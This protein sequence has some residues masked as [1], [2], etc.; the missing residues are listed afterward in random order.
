[1]END[2]VIFTDGSS[3]P[4]PR[5]GGLGFSFLFPDGLIKNFSPFGYIGATNNQME[6]QACIDAL[7]EILRLKKIDINSIIIRTD[8]KYVVDYHNLAK[9]VWSKNGWKKSNG[10]FVL[11]I[12]QW[13]DLLS[14]ENRIFSKFHI[15]VNYEKIKGHKGIEGN[16]RAHKSAKRSRLGP[17]C[18]K[19]ISITRVRRS[20]TK[21][22]TERGSICGL[23]QRISLRVV[24]GGWEKKLFRFRCEVMSKKSRFLGNMDFVWSEFPLSVGHTYFVVLMENSNFCQI[25]R[26]IRENKKN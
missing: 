9:F 18:M 21:K 22:E 3:A 19:K 7:R 17:S 24:S 25:K 23:G 8:S 11:N 12:R 6:L 15:Y 5:R 26:I 1:M 10:E 4:H 2:L 13:K 14:M 16:E 20:K